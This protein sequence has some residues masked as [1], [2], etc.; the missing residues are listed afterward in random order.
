[1]NFTDFDA[2]EFFG[3]NDDTSMF[4]MLVWILPVVIFVLYGQRIQLYI[5]STE[6]KKSIKKLDAYRDESKTELVQ[7]LREH[8]GQK[9]DHD[10]RVDRLLDYFTIHPV[11]IDPHGIVPKIRHVVR[12]R[13]EY[14]R[15][16]IISI[17]PDLDED[18]VNNIQTLLEV[19]TTLQMLYKI[20]NHLFLTAKKQKNYPLI[21]PLQMM[22]PFIMEEAVALRKSIPAFRQSQPVG[23]SIGP[24]IVGS[25][26][27]DLKKHDIAFQTVM[28]STVFEDRT[29]VLLKARGPS[30]TVGRLADALDSV[31]QTKKFDAII[32]IDAALKMEGEDSATVSHGFGAAIGGI[33][34]ERFEIEELATQN[35]IPIF[36]TIVKQS[37]KEALTLMTREIAEKADDIRQQ[38]YDTIRTNTKPGQAIVIMGVGNTV[39]IPQ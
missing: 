20:V 8:Y 15:R 31:M 34:T 32:M 4:M 26:M 16:N 30:S 13:E 17:I 18:Q 25:M 10:T 6:I 5:T 1:M 3:F 12:S 2:E 23:D 11:D 28:S 36:S 24:M 35:H 37:V 14:T 7:Y 39:G 29:L 38:I 19:A 33:G 27:L 22:L 9:I 21:L